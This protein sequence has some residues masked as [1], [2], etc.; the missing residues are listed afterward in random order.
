M[1]GAVYDFANDMKQGAGKLNIINVNGQTDA[2][3]IQETLNGKDIGN[4]H[5]TVK[6]HH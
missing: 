4:E 5:D 1:I 2:A 3:K 6:H